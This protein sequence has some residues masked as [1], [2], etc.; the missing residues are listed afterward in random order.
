[1]DFY[2]KKSHKIFE[3]SKNILK[4]TSCGLMAVA[5]VFLCGKDMVFNTAL[6]ATRAR[7]NDEL[8]DKYLFFSATTWRDRTDI[9]E[10]IEGKST[11][12]E[13]HLPSGYALNSKQPFTITSTS[14]T[15]PGNKIAIGSA[16]TPNGNVVKYKATATPGSSGATGIEEYVLLPNFSQTGIKEGIVSLG[17]KGGIVEITK[18]SL[19][20]ITES[21]M[22]WEITSVS[23]TTPNTGIALSKQI[24]NATGSCDIFN[25]QSPRITSQSFA[26]NILTINTTLAPSYSF[27]IEINL[28]DYEV[29]V[30]DKIRLS[31]F[32]P[33][34]DQLILT[35]KS[36]DII[37]KE[38]YNDIVND[39][40]AMIPDDTKKPYIEL[41]EGDFLTGIRYPFNLLTKVRKANLNDDEL[42]NISW[43]WVPDPQFANMPGAD[44][45]VEIPRATGKFLNVTLNRFKEDVTGKLIP[46][47][48][49]GNKQ[50]NPLP[51]EKDGVPITIVGSGNTPR[52][53]YVSETRGANGD[54]LI[55]NPSK[56]EYETDISKNKFAPR[57]LDAY[58]GGKL[59]NYK[60]GPNQPYKY[61]AKLYLGK[62]LGRAESVIIR[63]VKPTPNA[64]EIEIIIDGNT[65][66]PY[67][68]GTPIENKFETEAAITIEYYAT[69]KGTDDIQLEYVFMNNGKE[70]KYPDTVPNHFLTIRDSTP[71]DIKEIESLKIVS[72]ELKNNPNANQVYPNGEI[73]INFKPEQYNYP[74]IV[75]PYSV[76]RVKFFPFVNVFNGINKVI[77]YTIGTNQTGTYDTS[78]TTVTKEGIIVPLPNDPKLQIGI[79]T[80]LELEVMAEDGSTARYIFEIVRDKASNDNTLK[81]LSIVNSKDKTMEFINDK[82]FTPADPDKRVINLEIPYSV[83][84]IDFSAVTN[85]IFAKK[86][87]L[88]GVDSNNKK[89]LIADSTKCKV[90]AFNVKLKHPIDVGEYKGDSDINNFIITVTAENGL[91]K[92]YTIVIKR[93]P[94]DVNANLSKL[95]VL[96]SLGEAIKF[97][98]TPAFDK[99]NTFY[100]V[101]IPF[102]MPSGK[103]KFK[104]ESVVAQKVVIQLFNRNGQPISTDKSPQEFTTGL[105]NEQTYN[106]ICPPNN[107]N[108]T[109]QFNAVITIYP[110]SGL[111]D[112]KKTYTIRFLRDD[113]NKEN[114]LQDLKIFDVEGKEIPQL[115]F[116]PETTEYS[117]MVDYKNTEQLTIQP[118][119]MSNS[120]TVSLQ[121]GKNPPVIITEQN[122]SEVM[123]INASETKI[124]TITVKPEDPKTPAKVYKLTIRRNKPSNE[125]R[126]ESLVVNGGE[127]FSP[128]FVPNLTTYKVSIPE[129]TQSITFTA[130]P[131]HPNAT[132]TINKKK[133]V[134]GTPSEPYK[135][136]DP[137]TLVTIEVTAENGKTK[138]VYKIT[139][140]NENILPKSDNADLKSLVVDYGTMTPKFHPSVTDYKVAVKDEVTSVDIIPIPAQAH[141]KVEVFK[142]S[143]KLGDYSNNFS[144]SLDEG[145]NEITITVTAEDGKLK[146]T[147]NV[148]VYSKDEEHQGNFKPITSEMVNFAGANPIVVDISRYTVVSADVFNKLKKEYPNK[149]IIFQGNDYSL[150]IT[151]SAIPDGLLPYETTYDLGLSFRSPE[152]DKIFDVINMDPQNN[153]VEPVLIHFKHHG[154]LPGP[155]LFT[156]SLGRQYRDQKATWYYYNEERD[157]ID[158]YGE[159][160]TNSRGTFSTRINHM[161]TYI[162]SARYIVGA[163]NKTNTQGYFGSGKPNPNTGINTTTTSLPT[164]YAVLNKRKDD[165]Q[166]SEITETEE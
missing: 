81:S 25:G 1:M 11:M 12:L 82:N 34:K 152:Q 108:F 72:E 57:V 17:S 148:L 73:N 88:F 40:T 161:S 36:E 91:A 13:A 157:R 41:A 66:A 121:V 23:P 92:D 118:K 80:T 71:R 58:R 14:G 107:D 95:E 39:G 50:Y 16:S 131:V 165:E 20:I 38:I 120:S 138:K 47:V 162:Y 75:V 158:L 149:T 78:D 24:Q 56:L 18:G 61:K 26:N 60:G 69:K 94:P 137:Y 9:L 125:A 143:K 160:V 37:R 85:H 77:K 112:D 141:A 117:F 93:L 19:G 45:V 74:N 156:M 99:E 146:K 105:H 114:R 135:S 76:E 8:A 103:I 2:T 42:A 144:T 29:R 142:D 123:K 83:K 63:P 33:R 102:S 127:G 101:N 54:E 130:K 46:T 115:S 59:P 153:T 21:T 87:E 67:T 97:V 48:T 79:K 109:S 126:L 134:S 84:E 154:P 35:V 166:Y 68:L 147:Y 55:Q 136:Y 4:R 44:K 49:L 15:V 140:R 96:D 32:P 3:I 100:T 159:L 164:E 116:N 113:P 163:E 155:M 6:A 106:L 64:G 89:I 110:E 70:R 52:I 90:D 128:R 122:K 43:K 104:T 150:Q 145:E 10:I 129:G 7:A 22:E 31:F 124:V 133:L 151:G 62:G 86:I 27:K 111:K 30:G 139:V 5:M 98:G 132:M 53:E 65:A 28:D 119:A 51:D